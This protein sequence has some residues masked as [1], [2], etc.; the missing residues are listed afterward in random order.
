M[1][2]KFTCIL[3]YA[4]YVSQLLECMKI[5]YIYQDACFDKSD[6]CHV[7]KNV[8]TCIILL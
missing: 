3:F 4:N 5:V 1:Y 6:N 2:M 7:H 8:A